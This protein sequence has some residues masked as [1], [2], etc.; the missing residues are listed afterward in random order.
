[1]DD[2]CLGSNEKVLFLFVFIFIMNKDV[3]CCSESFSVITKIFFYSTHGDSFYITLVVAGMSFLTEILSGFNR[4][5]T[6]LKE[7]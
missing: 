3:I 7:K 6:Q 2:P 5:N 4:R 1:M